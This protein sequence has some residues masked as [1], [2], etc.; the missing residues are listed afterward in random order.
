MATLEQKV[1]ISAASAA[2]LAVVNLPQT[3]KFVNDI[4]PLVTYKSS[5]PTLLGQLV[6]LAVFA[7]L[8]YLSMPE[9]VNKGV[10]VKHTLYGSLIAFL[11]TSPAVYALV[12]SILGK[13]IANAKGCP[14]LMGVLLH[15]AVYGAALVG[16]MH[17]P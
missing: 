9:K 8:T 15:A 7:G 1:K 11:I 6:H 10:R 3:Y 2:M 17:L 12:G 16:V 14:T 4:L 13:T 5:C